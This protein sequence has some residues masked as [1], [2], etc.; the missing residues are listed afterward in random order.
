MG[1]TGNNLP[2]IGILV[3]ILEVIDD[4]RNTN[5]EVVCDSNGNNHPECG[6]C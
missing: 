2:L 4:I 3:G 6:C 1:W 5:G